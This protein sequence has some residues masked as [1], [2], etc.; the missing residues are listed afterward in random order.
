MR[1][2]LTVSTC[3]FLAICIGLLQEQSANNSTRGSP[4]SRVYYWKPDDSGNFRHWL[5]QNDALLNRGD[6]CTLRYSWMDEKTKVSTSLYEIASLVVVP[7]DDKVVELLSGG[8]YA[9]EL[10]VGVQYLPIKSG[11][12]G[13]LIALAFESTPRDVFDEPSRVEAQTIGRKDW[14]YL[15]VT[16][17]VRSADRLYRFNFMCE[18]GRAAFSP[19]RQN[20]SYAAPRP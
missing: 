11:A 7:E 9:A 10:R 20:K 15:T 1:S 14:T 3:L 8:E 12:S 5:A 13:I 2:A 18:N 17:E 6:A 16:K 4:S 19:F